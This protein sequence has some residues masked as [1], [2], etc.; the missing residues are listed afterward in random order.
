MHLE[1]YSELETSTSST[2]SNCDSNLSLSITSADSNAD[3]ETSHEEAMDIM[4]NKVRFSRLNVSDHLCV[5]WSFLRHSSFLYCESKCRLCLKMCITILSFTCQDDLA[6]NSFSAEEMLQKWSRSSQIKC[7]KAQIFFR[8]SRVREKLSYSLL[9]QT[10]C[11]IYKIW[12]SET[13][14][15]LSKTFCSKLKPQ[16]PLGI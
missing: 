7:T 14:E 13:Q 9:L 4:E 15:L 2:S 16:K 6:G 3:G 12:L 10:S 5:H 1:K 11:T 8:V